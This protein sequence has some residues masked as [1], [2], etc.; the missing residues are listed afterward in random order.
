MKTI[1]LAE[2]F[3]KVVADALALPERAEDG[4]I[5]DET[6]IEMVR[7]LYNAAH[8]RGVE[9]SIGRIAVSP[10]T[11]AIL[12]NEPVTVKSR[13]EL[14]VWAAKNNGRNGNRSRN[15]HLGRMT[16]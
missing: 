9:T 16:S 4:N 14:V 1:N 12:R 13:S 5:S 3:D 2:P 8:G 11:A 6:I 15:G 7:H 10:A